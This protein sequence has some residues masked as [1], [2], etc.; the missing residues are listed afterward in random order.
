MKFQ[1]NG[2]DREGIL[3][4]YLDLDMVRQDITAIIEGGRKL[5]SLIYGS[6][7]GSPSPPP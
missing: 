2:L 1:Y 4:R 5:L 3:S 6:R 7:P